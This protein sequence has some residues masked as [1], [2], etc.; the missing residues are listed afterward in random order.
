MSHAAPLHGAVTRMR[1]SAPAVTMGAVSQGPSRLISGMSQSS[2]VPMIEQARKVSPITRLATRMAAPVA[3]LHRPASVGALPMLQTAS[4]IAAVSHPTT[5]T[6]VT[7]TTSQAN[8]RAPSRPGSQPPSAPISPRDMASAW[9]DSVASAPPR[10]RSSE[11]APPARLETVQEERLNRPT[12]ESLA[13][14]AASGQLTEGGFVEELNGLNQQA[15]VVCLEKEVGT[16]QVTLSQIAEHLLNPSDL[17]LSIDDATQVQSIQATLKEFKASLEQQQQA[18]E[19][20]ANA[21]REG[22]MKIHNQS[23]TLMQVEAQIQDVK[24]K[25]WCMASMI[26]KA[27][28]VIHRLSLKLPDAREGSPYLAPVVEGAEL[29]VPSPHALELHAQL[30]EELVDVIARCDQQRMDLTEAVETERLARIGEASEIRAAMDMLCDTV[31]NLANLRTPSGSMDITDML[32]PRCRN[33]ELRIPEGSQLTKFSE[34]EGFSSQLLDEALVGLRDEIAAAQAN[35]DSVV[36][37]L[38]VKVDDMASMLITTK[39]TL[40]SSDNR[41]ELRAV[42]QLV[43]RLQEETGTFH[44][45]LDFLTELVQ[46]NQETEARRELPE[47]S[48]AETNDEDRGAPLSQVMALLRDMQETL[49]FEFAAGMEEMERK[50]RVAAPEQGKLPTQPRADTDELATR[51]E[52][53]KGQLRAE[54]DK[55]I[56]RSPGSLPAR[57]IDST[58]SSTTGSL[59]GVS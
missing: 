16:Q 51:L 15:Q 35:M 3:M 41:S 24:E 29:Q 48:S 30:A 17:Q 49:R 52:A 7:E 34:R 39:S 57:I 55:R 27:E 8:S 12:A 20:Q 13:S 43:A 50:T 36:G 54:V 2:S 26:E 38:V 9:V 46:N 58:L 14:Q 59:S 5:T 32:T 56:E 53:I 6:P 33:P 11:E 40:E 1:P 44:G 42:R 23:A 45:R 22:L 4:S 21:L 31:G 10:Q 28:K 47:A 25:E 18:Q 37:D 19:I